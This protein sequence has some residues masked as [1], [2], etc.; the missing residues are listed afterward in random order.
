MQRGTQATDFP[1]KKGE[2][3]RPNATRI[4]T[5]RAC[6]DKKRQDRVEKEGRKKEAANKENKAPAGALLEPDIV[7]DYTELSNLALLDF[8]SIIR[9]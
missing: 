5:C 4:N 8:L 7:V 1:F 9:G 2:V 6:N 3:P